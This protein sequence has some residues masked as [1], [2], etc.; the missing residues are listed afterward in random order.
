MSPTILFLGATGGVTNACLTSALKSNQWK[1]IALVRTPEKLR[2]QLIKQQGLDE[3]IIN[4]KLTI[5]QG[6]AIDISD[7]KRALLAN[8]TAQTD[9]NLPSMIVSG[10]GGTPALTFKICHP[11]QFVRVDNPTIC[12]DA[13]KTLITALREIFS[14]QPHLSSVRPGLCFVS[15]TGITRGPEDVPFSMRFLYHQILS[16]PHVDK[17]KMEDTYRDHMLQSGPVFESVTGIRPT[18][19]SGTGALSEGV[20]LRNIKA[21]VETKP[22][23]G[24]NVQRADV[25]AWM[26]EN[27]IMEGEY[28]K[29]RGEMVTLTA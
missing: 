5:I 9:K 28:G 23:L 13:A 4:N 2:D 22:A 12:E 15:T 25:G 21:G 10:L 1:A 20:G 3:T 19:L 29:W 17:K 14:E 24:F 6:N 26:Y 18:L 8:V 16:L 7:V 27:I 11:L